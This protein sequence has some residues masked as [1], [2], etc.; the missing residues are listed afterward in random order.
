MKL[1]ISYSFFTNKVMMRDQIESY[2]FFFGGKRRA[3]TPTSCGQYYKRP[4]SCKGRSK[5]SYVDTMT[6]KPEILSNNIIN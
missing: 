1:K 2:I 4:E 5:V 3:S 6:E